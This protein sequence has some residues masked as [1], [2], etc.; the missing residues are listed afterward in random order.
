MNELE[1]YQAYLDTPLPSIPSDIER[2]GNHLSVIISRTGQMYA[3]YRRQYLGVK[4][5]EIFQL[6]E[7][8]G[9]EYGASKTAINELIKAAARDEEHLMIWAERINKT[10]AK[11]LE[12]CRSLLSYAKAEISSS[13]YAT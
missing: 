12:W 9:E 1:K 6:L 5:T 3:D 13:K 7:K 11:Q 2:R 4:K 8:A 10:A